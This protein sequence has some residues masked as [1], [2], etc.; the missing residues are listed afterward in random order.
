LNKH[1]LTTCLSKGK[2]ADRLQLAAFPMRPGHALRGC[3]ETP[4]T[5]PAFRDQARILFAG[6]CFCAV[7][8]IAQLKLN[9]RHARIW[10][11]SFPQVRISACCLGIFACFGEYVMEA[12]KA[13]DFRMWAAQCTANAEAAATPADRERLIKMRDAL[14]A[15]ADN[16]D[17]LHG[18]VARSE[19]QEEDE[20]IAL[21][22][23]IV[24]FKRKT[25]KTFST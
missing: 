21:A 22:E 24:G 9:A 23:R 5:E 18:S 6:F 25:R 12:S 4:A 13:A 15:L 10:T 20:L 16:E 8:D 1:A 2:A 19:R 7:S 14:L 17:W 3:V 11:L